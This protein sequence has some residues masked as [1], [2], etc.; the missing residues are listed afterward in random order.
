[1]AVQLQLIDDEDNAVDST[2][3]TETQREPAVMLVPTSDEGTPLVRY[4]VV[5]YSLDGKAS[6]GDAQEIAGAEV[7]VSAVG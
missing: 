3:F 7:L 1:M 6:I 2:V 5:R 4:R